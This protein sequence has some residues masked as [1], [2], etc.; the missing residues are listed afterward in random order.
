M[1]PLS[2]RERILM[3]LMAVV[4]LVIGAPAFLG[5]SGQAKR[6]SLADE[7]RK[8]RELEAQL[9]QARAEVES[10]R[11]QIDRGLSAGTPRQLV[12][13][14]VE[15]AQAAARTAGVGLDDMKPLPL[16][17]NGALQGVPVQVSLSA[18]FPQAVRFVYE[19]ERRN[20]RCRVDQFR[21]V[22]TSPQNDNLE[23]DL[24]MVGYVKGEEEGTNGP[25]KSGG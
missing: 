6:S 11:A 16:E 22:A 9:S 8:R 3:G 20:G 7:R 12:Q 14:M 21:V 10:L 18:R 23:I 15:A 19:L 25:S 2:R 13:G 17:K 1:K 4:V 5:P 24:R